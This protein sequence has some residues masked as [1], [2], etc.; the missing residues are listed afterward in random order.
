VHVVV[1]KV[2][3]SV[4]PGN[5]TVV[6]TV[7]DASPSLVGLVVS[8]EFNLSTYTPIDIVT[9]IPYQGCTLPLCAWA[10]N[11]QPGR[12]PTWDTSICNRDYDDSFITCT[13]PAFGSV[14]VVDSVLAT[15]EQSHLFQFSLSMPPIVNS[16]SIEDLGLLG[17]ENIGQH[18]VTLL[19]LLALYAIFAVLFG[20]AYRFDIQDAKSEQKKRSEWSAA[21]DLGTRPSFKLLLKSNFQR[22]HVWLTMVRPKKGS[23][24]HAKDRVLG[25][26]LRILLV[27]ELSGSFHDEKEVRYVPATIASLVVIATTHVVLA[28]CFSRCGPPG[29]REQWEWQENGGR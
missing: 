5:G 9:S 25:S 21:R 22:N 4:G 15:D 20:Q 28:H 26:L 23:S 24:F 8:I 2:K 10:A 16:V 7:D 1:S 13:C 27:I 12:E 6:V 14:E 29:Y 19:C 18:P 17:A 3:V 11:I